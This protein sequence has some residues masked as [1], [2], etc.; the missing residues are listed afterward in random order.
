MTDKPSRVFDRDREWAGLVSYALDPGPGAR[1]GVVSGRRRQGKSYLLEALAAATGGLYFPAIEATEAVALRLFTEALI[2]YTGRPVRVPFRDWGDAI[3][4]LFSVVR[5]RPVPVVFDEFPF[6]VKA[7]PSLP[8]ILQRE[9]GPGGAGGDSLAR[10]VLCGSAMSVMGRLLAGQA[11]LRG[12]AGLEMLVRPFGYRDAATFWG[13]TDPRLAVLLH[14]VVGGTPA[15]RRE[16]VRF[17]APSGPDDFDDWIV[18]TV[19]NPQMPLFREARYLLAEETDIR[20]PGL[21]HSVLAA[22]AEGNRTWSGIANYVGRRSPEISHPLNVLEDC[23]LLVR[24]PDA[25]R[26]GRSSYRIIEP[27]ITFYQAIMRPE[28]SRLELGEA[29]A[30]WRDQRAVF[31]SRIVGPH[32]EALCREFALHAAPALF[33][34]PA[35]EVLSGVVNDPANRTQIEVDV[36]VFAP[37]RPGEPRRILSLG[38]AKWG[39]VMNRRHVERLARARDLLAVKGYDTAH[40]VLA[41]YSGAGFAEELRAEAARQPLALIDPERLYADPS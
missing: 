26:T 29:A 30:V 39:Q 37:G 40:T 6:L 36:V 21:Y 17:D 32:F 16:F 14:A 19:L 2:R 34:A 25:F 10:V 7:S 9:L 11:P 18:R 27:L 28:W 33:G 1:L 24:E 3:P 15:Y 5:D 23:G 20:D 12:R 13:V 31:L 22:V 4:Y 8:S 38:E 35:G 41:C